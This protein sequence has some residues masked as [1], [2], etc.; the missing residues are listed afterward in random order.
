[1]V[2]PAGHRSHHEARAEPDDDVV[3]V[4]QGHRVRNCEARA[5]GNGDRVVPRPSGSMLPALS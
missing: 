1:M 4:A 5:R 3:R 2:V